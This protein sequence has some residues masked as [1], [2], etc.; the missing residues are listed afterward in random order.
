MFAAIVFGIMGIGLL[1][2]GFLIKFGKRISM[3]PA[4]T[5]DFQRRIKK[6]DKVANDFGNGMI[7]LAIMVLIAAGGSYFF[8]KVGSIGGLV[9]IIIGASHWNRLSTS[10][11]S[12]IKKKEY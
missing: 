12:K 9:F 8:G 10:I 6:V 1:I 3:I 2:M 4:M 7:I 11:E 5:D